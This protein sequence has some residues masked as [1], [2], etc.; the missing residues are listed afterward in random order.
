MHTVCVRRQRKDGEIPDRTEKAVFA[1]V[2]EAFAVDHPAQGVHVGGRQ[3][4]RLALDLAQIQ[5]DASR[6]I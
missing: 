4:P 1:S 6:P 2:F 5:S 3:R